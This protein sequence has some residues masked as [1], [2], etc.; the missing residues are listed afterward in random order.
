MLVLFLFM[1]YD[2]H[3]Q[4]SVR[5]QCMRNRVL[6]PLTNSEIFGNAKICLFLIRNVFMK[7]EFE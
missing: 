4:R 1:F 2:K 7:T 5:I 3:L 6:A